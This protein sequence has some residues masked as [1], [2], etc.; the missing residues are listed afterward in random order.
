MCRNI[1]DQPDEIPPLPGANF[2]VLD[3]GQGPFSKQLPCRFDEADFRQR[4]L[5]ALMQIAVALAVCIVDRE[6][7]A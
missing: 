6:V 3:L 5:H 4:R 1:G 2:A 7:V